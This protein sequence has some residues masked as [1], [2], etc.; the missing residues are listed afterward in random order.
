ML[1]PAWLYSTAFYGALAVSAIALL[2][3]AYWPK[4]NRAR[5]GD[6]RIPPAAVVGSPLRRAVVLAWAPRVS[7]VGG[8]ALAWT[9]NHVSVDVI[10]VRGDGAELE[11]QRLKRLGTPTYPLAPGEQPHDETLVGYD[12]WIWNAS[13]KPVRLELFSYGNAP[14]GRGTPTLIPPGTAA[15][16]SSVDYIGPTSHPPET[17]DVDGVEAKIGT[18]SRS[19]LTWDR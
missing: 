12:T 18:T 7:L 15:V 13:S 9:L 17:I 8:V 16:T 1:I 2:Y 4:R 3:Y 6:G 5:P 11:A 10:R 19:W 14:W